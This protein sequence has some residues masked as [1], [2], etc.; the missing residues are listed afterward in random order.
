M[1]LALYAHHSVNPSVARHV[2]H[3][4]RELGKLGFQICFISNSSLSASSENELSA[5]CQ[6]IIQRENAGFDFC[7]WQR[8]LAEYDLSQIDE[9]LLTNSSIIGPLCPMESLWKSRLI[10][11]CDFWGLTDNCDYSVHLSSYFLVF[12]RGVIQSECFARFWAGVLPYT[13]KDQVIR[14][15]EIGLTRWLNQNGFK[16]AS[17]FA[18]KTIWRRYLKRRSLTRKIKDRIR[19]RRLPG[20]DTTLY[21]PRL[22]IEAGMPFLKAALLQPKNSYMRPQDAYALL[23]SS[24][25]PQEVLEELRP[26][27]S[28]SV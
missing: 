6:R 9:L 1:R 8:A 23:L 25:L 20:L 16:W 21:Y 12:R 17:V 10:E 15:Y 19:Q 2:V 11:G 27:E 13:E 26:H 7:M 3:H 14:G 22:L 24:D 5:F 4:L 18:Q 28:K